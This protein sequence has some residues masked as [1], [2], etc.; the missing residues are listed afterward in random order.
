MKTIKIFLCLLQIGVLIAHISIKIGDQDID[1]VT[2]FLQTFAHGPIKQYEHSF[3]LRHMKKFSSSFFQ[4]FGIMVTLVC[5]NLLTSALSPSVGPS[6]SNLEFCVN[7]NATDNIEFG[8]YHNTCWRMCYSENENESNFWC[9]T[10]P[11]LSTHGYISC[12]FHS[13]CSPYWECLN[14]CQSK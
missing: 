3:I 14:L 5:A 1:Q 4:M 12:A 11:N 9:Y 6:Q 2:D 13:D 10:S 7:T 8:C